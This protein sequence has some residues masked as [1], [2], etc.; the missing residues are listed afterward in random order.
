VRG[1][2]RE[3]IEELLKARF[4]PA[5]AG[6]TGE[7]ADTQ[8]ADAV[9]P[10]MCGAYHQVSWETVRDYGSSPHVRGILLAVVVGEADMRFIPACAGH[11]R[12]PECS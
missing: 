12:P 5:C 3:I 8:D 10:R 6:H 7:C 9:H 1:I 2:L 11:T 4:I